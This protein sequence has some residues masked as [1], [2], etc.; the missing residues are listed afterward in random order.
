MNN[1]SPIELDALRFELI[2]QIANTDDVVF[3]SKLKEM[4]H[5]FKQG[6]EIKPMTWEELDERLTKA[7][8]DIEAGRVKSHEDFVK[9]SENW[10]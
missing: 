2:R 4:Y 8:Q 6:Q 5:D 10:Q 7:H 9:E 1:M 3:L